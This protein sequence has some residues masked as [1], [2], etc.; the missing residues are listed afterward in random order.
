MPVA[1][2]ADSDHVFGNGSRPTA[3]A[4]GS[5]EAAAQRAGAGS[6]CR[7]HNVA[8]VARVAVEPR[9]DLCWGT[10]PKAVQCKAWRSQQSPREPLGNRFCH[11]NAGLPANHFVIQMKQVL[12]QEGGVLL[13]PHARPASPIVLPW[14]WHQTGSSIPALTLGSSQSGLEATGPKK[15]SRGHLELCSRSGQR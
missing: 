6:C 7:P 11:A 5:R 14:A 10:I 1:L 9:N 2:E 8:F 12:P 3:R 4:P 15:R 13:G